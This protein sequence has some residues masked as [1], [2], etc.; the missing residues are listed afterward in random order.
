MAIIEVAFQQT[1]FVRVNARA[2]LHLLE[3]LRLVIS[4]IF[5]LP[6]LPSRGEGGDGFLSLGGSNYYK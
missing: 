3:W 4:Y 1:T 5:F 2:F 6:C